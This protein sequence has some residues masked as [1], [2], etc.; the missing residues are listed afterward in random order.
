MELTDKQM[1]EING[2]IHW[3]IAAGITAGIVYL[4]G[5]FSG[6]TNPNRCYN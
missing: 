4:I 5:F 6:Y 2:G 1:N 3:S